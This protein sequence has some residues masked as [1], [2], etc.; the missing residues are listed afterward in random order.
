MNFTRKFDSAAIKA[1]EAQ[2]FTRDNATVY[3]M[4][5]PVTAAFSVRGELCVIAPS[6]LRKAERTAQIK[7]VVTRYRR[8]L[9][10]QNA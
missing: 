3:V 5:T 7:D 2:S 9:E 8:G 1:I 4:N 10:V 6:K